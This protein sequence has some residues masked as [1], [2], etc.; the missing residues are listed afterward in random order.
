MFPLAAMAGDRV[1]ISY[2]GNIPFVVRE[3]PGGGGKYQLIGECY[4]DGFM[5]GPAIEVDRQSGIHGSTI[6]LV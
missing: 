3:V 5:D 1:A 4:L 6:M 2:G